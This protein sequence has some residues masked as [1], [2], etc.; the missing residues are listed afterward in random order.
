VKK[1]FLDSHQI[2]FVEP[3]EIGWMP[4]KNYVLGEDNMFSEMLSFFAKDYRVMSWNGVN[5]DARRAGSLG[6]GMST[7]TRLKGRFFAMYALWH[8]ALKRNDKEFIAYTRHK[9]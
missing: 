5:H 1:S 2:R 6:K 3:S 4:K 9:M 8:D 7:K